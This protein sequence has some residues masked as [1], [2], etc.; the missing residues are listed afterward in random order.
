LLLS[1]PPFEPRQLS[2][3]EYTREFEKLVIKC[4]LHKPEEQTIIRYL[5]GLDPRYANVVDLQAHTSFDE[6]CVL[7]HKVEQQKK[8]KH[9]LRHEISKPLPHE[10]TVNKGSSSST[11]KPTASI[12]PIPGQTPQQ[13][14]PPQSTPKPLPKG[15]PRCFKCKGFWHL[16]SDCTNRRYVSLAEWKAVDEVEL[17][18]ENE[19]H[20]G[21]NLEEIVVEVDEGEMLTLDTHHPARSS[22]HLGLIITFDEPP[23]LSPTPPITK[24]PK[25]NFC[26]FIPGPLLEAPNSE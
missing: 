16:A 21:D 12:S 22:E 25:Q 26:Q 10:Q 20:D 5:G 7:A 19:E 18:E 6:V 8:N 24:M 17:E 11:S 15:I 3:E 13:S 23:N 1:T 9:P 4:D 14:L 2:V